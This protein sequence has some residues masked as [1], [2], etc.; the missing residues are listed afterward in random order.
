MAAA[1]LIKSLNRAAYCCRVNIFF[2]A[3]SCDWRVIG[4]KSRKL[5]S[6]NRKA[7]SIA[8]LLFHFGAALEKAIAQWIADHDR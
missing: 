8:R 1:P 2:S 7:V 4:E 5:H 6:E 3:W